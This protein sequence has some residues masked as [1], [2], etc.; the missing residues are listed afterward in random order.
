MKL[1]RYA[2]IAFFVCVSLAG[3]GFSEEPTTANLKGAWAR[4]SDGIKLNFEFKD[5][6]LEIILERDGGKVVIDCDYSIG[7][8][9]SIFCRVQELKEGNANLGKG[10][11]FSFSFDVSKDKASM[12]DL[13]SK[14][15]D[16]D[17][18]RQ[19]KMIVEGEYSKK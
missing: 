6:T 4:E 9:R 14:D 15:S 18:G 8:D 1:S 16:S 5:K 10:D 17:Q 3:N 2:L 19:I 13:K 11:T 12:A 7:R